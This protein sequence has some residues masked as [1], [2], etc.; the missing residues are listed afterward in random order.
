MISKIS[1]G[2]VADRTW[3][4]TIAVGINR[5]RRRDKCD[6]GIDFETKGRHD[7]HMT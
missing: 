6:R 1:V 4:T 3:S 2:D 5:V 7:G